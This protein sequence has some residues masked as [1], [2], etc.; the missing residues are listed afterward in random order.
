MEAAGAD[1][2]RCSLCDVTCTGT[3]AFNA[4]LKGAKHLKVGHKLF[5]GIINY[6]CPLRINLDTGC[7]NSRTNVPEVRQIYGLVLLCF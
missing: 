2:Y 6:S 1:G 5:S 3:D 7:D 4:H